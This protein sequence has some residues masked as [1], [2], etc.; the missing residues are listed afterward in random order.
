MC[1][2]LADS[3]PLDR[4]PAM[5]ARLSLPAINTQLI[6]ILPAAIDPINGCAIPADAL[7]QDASHAAPQ[8]FGLL[9]FN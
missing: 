7:L 4:R 9:L 8:D 6:L 5:G 3:D 1:A 2:T